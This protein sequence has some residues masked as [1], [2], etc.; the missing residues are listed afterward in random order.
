MAWLDNVVRAACV[1]GDCYFA[2]TV[3]GLFIFPTKGG[4]VQHLGTT[5]GLPSEDIHA[6]A[7][8]DG[9][10]YIGAGG[11][12]EGYLVS[13]D[14]VTRKVNILGS[15]RRSEHLSP[16]DDQP[17]FYTIG[18]VADTHQH[19]LLMVVS[20]TIIP[21]GTLPAIA[22][23]MGIW[24][25]SPLAGEYKRLAPFRLVTIPV[26]M[27]RQTWAGLVNASVLAT[28]ETRTLNLFDLRNDRLLSVYDPLAAQKSATQSPWQAPQPGLSYPWGVIPFDGPFL[29]REGWFY[30]ARPF[31]RM[32]LADGRREQL[33]PLRTDYPFELRESLQLL[34]DGKHILAADQYSIWLLEPGP[35]P[36]RV[37]VG[38]GQ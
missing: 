26:L 18:F 7:F 15:S 17:P 10:L 34:D 22:P 13:Y 1:G 20:S 36:A 38:N 37:S 21:T 11:E 3:S 32:A 30:S 8:L 12:R 4:P 33:P 31:A 35:E 27:P 24:S 16:F 28:K 9:K 6:I 5:N 14:P 29:L 2:A 23:C 25:Y 19:R